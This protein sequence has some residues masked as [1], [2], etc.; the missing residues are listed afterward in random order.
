MDSVE[1]D[2]VQDGIAIVGMSG[3]FPGARNIAEFWRNLRDGVES[4]TFF[5]DEELESA[6]VYPVLRNDPNYVRAG[7]VLED[8][9]LFDAAFFGFNPREAESVDPQA[10]SLSGVRLR[11]PGK[12]RLRPRNVQGVGRC[13]WR[14]EHEH[15]PAL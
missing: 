4:I 15:L 13:L 12:C 9:E 11:D 7:G 5:S 14:Y 1:T 6:N 2:Q 10:A 8:V 3:R